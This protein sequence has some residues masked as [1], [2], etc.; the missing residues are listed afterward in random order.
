M[1]FRQ[2]FT[3]LK[4]SKPIRH[5]D[6]IFMAGSCFTEQMSQKLRRVKFQVTENPHG[7]LFNP[8]SIATSILRYCS[9][10]PYLKTDLFQHDE[11]W[12]SW[13][14]HTRFSETD[15]DV[16]LRHINASLQLGTVALKQ[17]RWLILTLGS[18]FV[19]QKNDGKVVA[20]CHKVPADRF[21]KKLMHPDE[22]YQNF[23]DMLD[24]LEQTCPGVN[25]MLTISPVRHLRD[26]FVENN[27]SKSHL[28]QAVH[29]LVETRTNVHYF[30]S[31]ELVIDDLRD[32]RFYAEDMVH[33]NYQATQYV[34]ERF[35]QTCI[36]ERDLGLIREMNQLAAAMAHRIQHPGTKQHRDFFQKQ[37]EIIRQLQSAYPH[38]NLHE[39]M[40]YFSSIRL[41][42]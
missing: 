32:Y 8:V 31:Y 41:S 40:E 18:A 17:A 34:Y 39:E 16:C 27:R 13:E 37:V 12:G 25:V 38:L 5:A 2:P 35:L 24:V 22:I 21:V 23:S 42:Q 9:G 26:G 4:L 6:P 29:A 15:P 30:P 1:E 14:H 3:P 11:L 19:Y 33:P 7:I 20:N 36:D 10:E 28:I